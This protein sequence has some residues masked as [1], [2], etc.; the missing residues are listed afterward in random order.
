MGLIGEVHCSSGAL[1]VGPNTAGRE[2]GFG[3]RGE[4]SAWSKLKLHVCRVSSPELYTV[5]DT[6]ICW[7]D[8]T[9]TDGK[10]C[11]ASPCAT[12]VTQRKFP[13]FT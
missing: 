11:V 13:G 4:L 5:V 12:F 1:T 7:G 10:V 8:I 3:T 6:G 2:G 9:D